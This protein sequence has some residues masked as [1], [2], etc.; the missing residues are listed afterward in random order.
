M[1]GKRLPDVSGTSPGRLPGRLPDVSRDVS[2][3]KNVQLSSILPCRSENPGIPDIPD[4]P[5]NLDN[6][7]VPDIPD[8]LNIPGT[9]LGRFPGRLCGGVGVGVCVVVGG[10]NGGGDVGEE[11]SPI[12]YITTPDRPLCGC[13]WY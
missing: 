12:L 3:L 13:Y 5:D 1:E 11:I 2:S 8:I 9:S 4:N 7:D 6:L 10:G